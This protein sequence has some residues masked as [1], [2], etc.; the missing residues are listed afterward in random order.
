MAAEQD[1]RSKVAAREMATAAVVNQFT[2]PQAFYSQLVARRMALQ[3]TADKVV[4]DAENPTEAQMM[5]ASD[6]A[7]A[8]MEAQTKKAEFDALYADADDPKVALVNELI[9]TDG[10]DG[11]AL[12][13]A[14]SSN[15]GTANEAKETADRVAESV[16]G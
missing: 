11:Q 10:D 6:A 12:V 4:A 1:L 16:E 13:D 15:Y 14:I 8:L 2:A 7:E 5:A 3:A 9:K